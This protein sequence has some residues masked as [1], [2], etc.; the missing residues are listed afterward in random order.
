[1][2]PMAAYDAQQYVAREQDEINQAWITKPPSDRKSPSAN[3]LLTEEMQQCTLAARRSLH[4][5][6]STGAKQYP[7]EYNSSMQN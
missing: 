5:Y 3:I 2:F 6:P 4:R 7:L 1:M